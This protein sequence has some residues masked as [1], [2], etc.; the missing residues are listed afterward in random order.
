M[1]AGYPA[2]RATPGARISKGGGEDLRVVSS[3]PGKGSQDGSSL[4]RPHA[5]REHLP[6]LQEDTD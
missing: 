5:V 4:T 6:R 2:L 3:P 1:V